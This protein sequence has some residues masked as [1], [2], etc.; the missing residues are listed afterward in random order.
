MVEPAAGEERLGRRGQGQARPGARSEEAG[1]VDRLLRRH[2]GD[3]PAGEVLL[4][5]DLLIFDSTFASRH[6]DLAFERKHSTAPEAAQLAKEA[7]AKRLVLTHFS[8]RY[9]RVDSLLRE[10]QRVFPDT[11]AAHDGLVLELP[12]AQ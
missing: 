2:E 10:A 8:A 9:R 12:A 11:V 3:P 6:A 4:R 5:V 1:E 7:G